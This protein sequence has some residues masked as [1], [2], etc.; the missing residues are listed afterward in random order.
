MINSNRKIQKL[1]IGFIIIVASLIL[2]SLGATI[3]KNIQLSGLNSK[4]INNSIAPNT[5]T[6]PSPSS[7][8]SNDSVGFMSKKIG[9]AQIPEDV[10]RSGANTENIIT[11]ATDRKITR[12]GNLEI[13]VINV[14]ETTNTIKNLVRSDV[15]FVENLNIAENKDESKV[16]TITIRVT[17]N[18]FDEVVSEIKKLAVKV[19][20]ETEFQNDT[21]D[22]IIE[23]EVR[24]SSIEKIEKQYLELLKTA[25][26]IE[27]ILAIND[28]LNSTRYEIE[29]LKATLKEANSRIDLATINISLE[30]EVDVNVLGIRWRPI[31]EIKQALREGLEDFTG[32]LNL[33]FYLVASLPSVVLLFG[34]IIILIWASAELFLRFNITSFI[35]KFFKRFEE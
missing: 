33:I 14:N 15:G 31:I 4:I 28:R 22:R 11:T 6:F 29:Y 35:K 17:A 5:T 30:E 8:P 34:T 7:L 32:V 2:F 20:T 10:T 26:K 23:L 1:I 24:I 12:N 9:I 13:A 16:A 27:D 18:K 25:K 3:V 19:K 21:T